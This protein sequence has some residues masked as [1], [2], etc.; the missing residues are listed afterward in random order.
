MKINR[1]VIGFFSGIALCIIINLLSLAELSREGQLC[2]GLTLMTVV[3]WATQVAQSGYVSAVFLMLLCLL[4]VASPTVIFSCW[5]NSTMWLV[6]GAYLIATA[7]RNSG[8]GERLSYTFILKFVRGW[9]DT[10]VSIFALTFVLS[11][12]IP[13]PWPRALLIM[14]VMRIIIESTKMS[15]RDAVTVGLTVFASSVPISLI[16]LTG[17]ATIN[18]LVASYSGESV[19]FLR[20]FLVIGPPAIV[21]SICT[22]ILILTFFR[23]SSSLSVDLSKIRL[24]LQG[25]GKMTG[26]EKRV[27]VW[28]IIAVLFWMTNSITGLDIGWTTL[29]VAVLM[30]CPVIG[31][32]LDADDW[33]SI[34]VDVL[35]FL[36]A[37]M[38]V[39]SVGSQT[40]MSAWI[41]NNLLPSTVPQNPILLVLLI[42][43]ISIIL[44]LFMGSVMAVVGVAIPAI[45][46]FTG[47]A[48]PPLAVIG[49]VYI[50]VGGHYLMP[51]H[52]INMLI[53]QGEENGL[54]TQKETIKL[55][56]PLSLA[57][58]I[59]IL[60][61]FFWWKIIGLL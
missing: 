52:H 50:S 41:A 49:I 36:T 31:E 57:V 61:A 16:F 35:I 21:L 20:W 46:S 59:S 45:L 1:K 8:L 7:V 12:F 19:S 23:P 2:L 6:F 25:L 4:K 54:Y 15:Q 10:I 13:S 5:T 26:Y 56:A 3:W 32:V 39:G 43:S 44:H 33:S 58:L 29:L 40:G 53:G 18:P 27:L 42:S 9:N 51:F 17:D 47:D 22:L 37:A 30:S 60:F 38:A 11:L 55:G 34:P 48:L 28:I 24:S 14:S